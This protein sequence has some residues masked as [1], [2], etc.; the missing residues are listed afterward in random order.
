MCNYSMLI[1]SGCNRSMPWHSKPS[2]DMIPEPFP[3]TGMGIRVFGLAY[4]CHRGLLCLKL[5]EQIMFLPF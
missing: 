2:W 4:D 1:V 5:W 3:C